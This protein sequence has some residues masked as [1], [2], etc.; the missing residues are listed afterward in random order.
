MGAELQMEKLTSEGWNM[1][2]RRSFNMAR[3]GGRWEAGAN[4]ALGD[5]KRATKARFVVVAA[6]PLPRTAAARRCG[7]AQC[8]SAAPC[9][10]G[11]VAMLLTRR[12]D[13]MS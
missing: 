2:A 6:P 1:E 10:G 9:L 3:R 7:W 11:A 8:S 4:T 13:V 12:Q 5:H